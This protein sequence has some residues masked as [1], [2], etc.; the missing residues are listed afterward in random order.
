MTA[1]SD[2]LRDL[3]L[4]NMAPPFPGTHA[5]LDYASAIPADT[6]KQHY[7]V[8]PRYWYV[9]ATFRCGRCQNEFCFS[10]EEQ[11]LWYE[12]YFIWVFVHPSKCQSCRRDLRRL[13]SLRRKYD[14]EISNA[15]RTKDAQLKREIAKVIDDLVQSG[16]ALPRKLIENR[17]VL[18]RQIA[19]H[20][21]GERPN[22]ASPP[23]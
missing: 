23:P 18:A 19:C 2:R 8:V 9:D 1:V 22:V 17:S 21:N 5:R 3:V 6:T 11:K 4:Q 7:T 10:A 20:D 14:Q 15:I 13:K 16:M 12:E